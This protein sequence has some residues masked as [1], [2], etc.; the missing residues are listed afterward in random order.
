[1]RKV[2]YKK[3]HDFLDMPKE[4][5]AWHEN[6]IADEYKELE[7]ARGFINRWS[8]YSD[9]VYTVTRGRW[10]GHD[11]GSPLSTGKFIYGSIYMFPKTTLRYLFF[12]RAGKKARAKQPL[13][14]VRNPKKTHKL[15]HIAKKYDLDPEEFAL[16]CKKQLRYWLLPK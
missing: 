8:E 15:H 14:E 16:I 9:V 10:S 5:K 2:T 11:L 3:W 1:M 7:E 4:D 13:R 12:R 6:D